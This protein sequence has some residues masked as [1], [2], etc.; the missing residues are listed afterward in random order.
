MMKLVVVFGE[1]LNMKYKM[2]KV[3]FCG[4]PRIHDPL[5]FE[6][7]SSTNDINK[8]Y[9]RAAN[10][11]KLFVAHCNCNLVVEEDK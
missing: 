11:N 1:L 2:V 6:Y 3:S 10:W 7:K 5:G 8:T 9:N 4:N